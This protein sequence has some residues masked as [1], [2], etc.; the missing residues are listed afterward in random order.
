MSTDL[1]MTHAQLVDETTPV[2]ATLRR[3]I[4][5]AR[6]LALKMDRPSSRYDHALLALGEFE[7][8]MKYLVQED[9]DRED[10]KRA[11]ERYQYQEKLRRALDKYPELGA[12]VV[13]SEA[14]I[15]SILEEED[16]NG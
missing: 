12:N 4:R 10:A 7:A 11:A 14:T 16:A 2:I 8:E 3:T 5:I 9:I 6:E 15:D 13:I 1:E